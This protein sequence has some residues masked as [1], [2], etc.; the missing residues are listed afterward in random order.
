MVEEIIYRVFRDSGLKM[1]RAGIPTEETLE[2][3]GDLFG[4]MAD[5]FGC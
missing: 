2:I 1:L 5:E 3:L 4:A